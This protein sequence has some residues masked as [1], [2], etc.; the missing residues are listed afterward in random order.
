MNHKE[1]KDVL[2]RRKVDNGG[3]GLC[4]AVM[5][6]SYSFPHTFILFCSITYSF[7]YFHYIYSFIIIY[8]C[9]LSFVFSFFFSYCSFF[10]SLL[11]V[12]IYYYLFFAYSHLF[13]HS[14]FLIAFCVLISSY[15]IY[16]FILSVSY[17]RL[18]RTLW[19]QW[20]FV[21]FVFVLVVWFPV[22]VLW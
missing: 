18:M 12:F 22:V 13:T 10:Y 7:F 16:H 21:V 14:F 2:Q 19:R 15:F 8:F 11:Y 3:K 4:D 17:L 1:V 5:S 6:Y 9:L 20:L